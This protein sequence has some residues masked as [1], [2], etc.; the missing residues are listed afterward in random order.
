MPRRN[1]DPVR[2]RMLEDRQRVHRVETA[3]AKVEERSYGHRWAGPNTRCR[4][5]M[6]RR[7]WLALT[8]DERWAGRDETVCPLW[9]VLDE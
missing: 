3:R 2:V 7:A 8:A 6:E 9:E 4:C 5:G 1:P